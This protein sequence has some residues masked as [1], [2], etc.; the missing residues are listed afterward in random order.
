MYKYLPLILLLT[1]C[2]E[3]VEI[4]VQINPFVCTN[5]WQYDLDGNAIVDNT[6][7]QKTCAES[8]EQN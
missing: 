7:A 3:T 2:I 6:G 8:V 4:P 5:G 1:A